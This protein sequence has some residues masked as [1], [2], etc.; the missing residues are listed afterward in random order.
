MRRLLALGAVVLV[1]AGSARMAQA[2][3]TVIGLSFSWAGTGRCFDPQPPAFRLSE[4]PAG[5]RILRFQMTDL[6]APHFMHGGGDV[7]W[8]GQ[9]VIPRGAFTYRGPCPPGGQHRY[10]WTVTALGAGGAALGSGSATQ[11]FPP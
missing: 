10:R 6:D 3:G 8:S 2:Q 1:L 4:V 7:A 9:A 5:T 11:P